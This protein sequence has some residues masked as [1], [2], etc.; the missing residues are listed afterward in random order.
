M[1]KV[2]M[3]KNNINEMDEFKFKLSDRIYGNLVQEKIN[4]EWRY[5]KVPINK[6]IKNDI[7][8]LP[9]TP[10]HGEVY[11]TIGEFLAGA[12]ISLSWRSNSIDRQLSNLGLVC[13]TKQE[14]KDKLNKIIEFCKKEFTA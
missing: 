11:Y 13:R 4:G 8:R 5:S 2:W 10:K 1:L 14:A 6:F 7:V 9:W 12:T 3:E